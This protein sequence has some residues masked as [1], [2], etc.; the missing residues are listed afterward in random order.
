MCTGS[1]Q[2]RS[3][4]IRPIERAAQERMPEPIDIGRHLVRAGRSV[5]W[6]GFAECLLV[7]LAS[8]RFIHAVAVAGHG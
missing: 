3:T 5:G 2:A 8:S 7:L 6:V 4:R 1:D